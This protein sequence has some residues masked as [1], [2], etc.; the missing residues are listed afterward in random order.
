MIT[1]ELTGF[2]SFRLDNQSNI[3]YMDFAETSDM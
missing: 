1:K 2:L 3:M